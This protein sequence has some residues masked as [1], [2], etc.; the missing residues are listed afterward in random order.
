MNYKELLKVG[1]A[2]G[3]V[4]CLLVY[5]RHGLDGVDPA[6]ACGVYAIGF[7]YFSFIHVLLAGVDRLRGKSRAN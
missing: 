5:W 4:M 3:F 2:G 7:I 1:F 6:S